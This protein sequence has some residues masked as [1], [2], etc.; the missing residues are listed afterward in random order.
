MRGRCWRSG[1]PPD[2]RSAVLPPAAAATARP[3]QGTAACPPPASDGEGPVDGGLHHGG[4]AAICVHVLAAICIYNRQRTS[5]QGLA[6]LARLS[7]LLG[8][9]HCAPMLCLMPVLCLQGR[10]AARW[11]RLG[12]VP[13]WCSQRHERR[14][15]GGVDRGSGGGRGGGEA[16]AAAAVAG[17]WGGG[18]GG[19]GGA[20]RTGL[21]AALP[22]Q[23][24]AVPRGVHGGGGAGGDMVTGARPNASAGC[25]LPRPPSQTPPWCWAGLVQG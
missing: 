3:S 12:G 4:H 16:A 15:Q 11:R 5:G 14:V 6:M 24:R 2:C 13:C 10:Q 25:M 9:L 17:G 21:L 8:L 20:W 18:R 19:R 23:P 7:Q 22:G 1:A